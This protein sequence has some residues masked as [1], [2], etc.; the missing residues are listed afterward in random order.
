MLI[1][2][3]IQANKLEREHQKKQQPFDCGYPEVLQESVPSISL[4]CFALDVL[5]SLNLFST[6]IR[7]ANR[8]RR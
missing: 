8:E 5:V 2:E 4:G 6:Q 7:G 1:Y 3:R